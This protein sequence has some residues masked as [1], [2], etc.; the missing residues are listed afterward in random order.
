M[1]FDIL[2]PL[3]VFSQNSIVKAFSVAQLGGAGMQDV[4]DDITF[5]QNREEIGHD[6]SVTRK[7]QMTHFGK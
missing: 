1:L 6:A 4:S 3:S 5:T 7:L 2:D